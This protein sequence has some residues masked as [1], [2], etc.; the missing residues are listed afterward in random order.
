MTLSMSAA[1]ATERVIGP[2]QLTWS[3][4]A[5]GQL[6]TRPKLGFSPKTPQKCDGIRI[7]PAPSDPWCNGP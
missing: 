5:T 3:L 4:L 2:A 7:D 1:S 6:G